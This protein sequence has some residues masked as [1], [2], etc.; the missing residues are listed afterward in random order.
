MASLN[1]DVFLDGIPSGDSIYVAGKY[2]RWAS[3]PGS[4]EPGWAALFGALANG[5]MAAGDGTAVAAR[6]RAGDRK[7]VV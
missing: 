3:D 5:G 7:S 1:L 2:D 6:P 4:V